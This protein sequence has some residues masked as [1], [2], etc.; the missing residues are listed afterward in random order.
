MPP[1]L[2]H[3]R[4]WEGFC[5]QEC[6]KGA[7]TCDWDDKFCGQFSPEELAAGQTYMSGN[8]PAKTMCWI[9]PTPSSMQV[10]PGSVLWFLAGCHLCCH[11]LSRCG[12]LVACGLWPLRVA[13]LT[14]QVMTGISHYMKQAGFVVTLAPMSTAVYTGETDSSPKQNQRN[15]FVKWRKQPY[16]G[17]KPIDG[18]QQFDLLE[19]VDGVLLQWYSGFDA[20][21][22]L[23]SKDPKACTCDNVPDLDY[24]NTV[25]ATSDGLISSYYFAAGAGGNMFPT[26]FPVRCQACGKNVILPNG[27]RGDLPCAPADEQWFTPGDGTKNASIY[28]DHAAK[29]NNY[30]ATHPNSI[31]YWWVQNLT[32]NSKC[33]RGL[34]C[35]D[36][37]YANEKRYSR[38]VSIIQPLALSDSL[39][40]APCPSHIT[41]LVPS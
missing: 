14:R 8:P 9:M 17:G 20:S 37:Q 4:D 7:C 13:A 1:G 36:W 33:P 40:L 24:N 19:I 31:P 2:T 10:M 32:V 25:N 41:L 3:A 12:C 6:L 30:V 35:P 39:L 16:P 23:N 34:D 38:Q 29:L 15:E 11:C 22:C 18:P 27:T 26:T 21:L 28:A 5:K